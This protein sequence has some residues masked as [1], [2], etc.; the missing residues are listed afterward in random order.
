MASKI[1]CLWCGDDP[2]YRDYHD[3]EW[4][5]PCR[6]D[7]KLF[8]FL[9]LEGAQAGLSWI[10]ILRKRESYRRA[11]AKFD[12]EKVA[13]FSDGDIQRLTEDR[14]IVRNRSKIASAVTNA[15]CYLQVID[16][17]G[18][19]SHYLWRHVDGEPLVN[20]WVDERDI[21]A[22]TPLSDCISEDMK[23]RGFKFFGTTICYAYLQAMGL[24]NDHVAR[25]FRHRQCQTKPAGPV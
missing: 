4:G 13:A 12:V 9:I 23:R 5:V 11:F 19:F 24:V 17:F 20:N 7:K 16:E 25:C 15:R 2:L 1:R 8:E 22:R 3:T 14:G 21:P 10:T 18:S 6:D